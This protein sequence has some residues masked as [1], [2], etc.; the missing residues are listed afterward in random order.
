MA[1]SRFGKPYDRAK[2]TAPSL[3]DEAVLEVLG[4]AVGVSSA[5]AQALRDL[6]A[7]RQQGEDV[8]CLADERDL[9][10]VPRLDLPPGLTESGEG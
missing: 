10:V 3:I 5:P 4:H 1:G 8:V 2:L 9:F 7:R 6:R